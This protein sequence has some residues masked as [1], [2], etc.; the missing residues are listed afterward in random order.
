ML[1][2]PENKIG[3]DI[4]DML[5]IS[6]TYKRENKGPGTEPWE[7]PCLTGSHSE[8]YSLES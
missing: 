8:A 5:G 6:L 1:L 7:I 4:S 3:L 2:W